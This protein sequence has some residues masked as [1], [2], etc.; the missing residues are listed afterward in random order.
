MAFFPIFKFTSKDL[1]KTVHDHPRLTNAEKRKITD[2]DTRLIRHAFLLNE[3]EERVIKFQE[4]LP[5]GLRPC[6]FKTLHLLR[7]LLEAQ[8]N[9]RHKILNISGI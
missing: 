6:S 3:R 4:C 5:E 1:F 8:G 2:I 9:L 7:R